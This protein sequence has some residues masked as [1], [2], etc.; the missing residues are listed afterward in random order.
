MKFFKIFFVYGVSACGGIMF[1]VLLVGSI[2]RDLILA[3]SCKRGWYESACIQARNASDP[4]TLIPQFL[5]FSMV[6]GVV[7][8][9]SMWLFSG[10]DKE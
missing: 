2:L 6:V 4:F 10:K 3:L 5:L 8:G 1:A 7:M 9:C